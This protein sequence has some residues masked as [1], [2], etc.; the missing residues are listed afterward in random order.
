[1]LPAPPPRAVPLRKRVRRRLRYGLVRGALA[2]LQLLPLAWAQALGEAV[3]GLGYRVAGG[4]RRRALA[5]LAGGFPTLPAAEREALARAC[6]RH[7]GR[8]A[9]ELVCVRHVD[10]RME[11]LVAWPAEDRAVLEAALARGR[12]V[13]FVTGHVGSW[14]LLARRVASAGFPSQSIA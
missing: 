14:E 10:A 13:V 9:L 6:F 12:G 8:M 7:L 4:E 11:A 2:L 3:G 5:S 1:A